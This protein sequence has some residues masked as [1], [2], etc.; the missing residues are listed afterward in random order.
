M[1]LSRKVKANLLLATTLVGLNIAGCN[2]LRKYEDSQA[3]LQA[4]EISDRII[5]SVSAIKPEIELDNFRANIK[6]KNN[7]MEYRVSIE[8]I[9]R[10][11]TIER[12]VGKD[13]MMIFIDRDI[14]GTLDEA[15]I[16]RPGEER[17]TIDRYKSDNPKKLEGL[18]RKDLKSVY[19][20]L[21][22]F[23]LKSPKQKKPVGQLV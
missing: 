7:G 11:L 23:D 2:E 22:K 3:R 5:E 8:N 13:G 18:F 6:D 10:T 17:Y 19:D 12:K 14:D 1:N 4:V 9:G 21:Q 16:L 15:Y 20:L